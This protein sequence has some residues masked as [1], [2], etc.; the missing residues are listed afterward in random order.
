MRHLSCVVGRT[1]TGTP[2]AKPSADVRDPPKGKDGS[3][4]SAT[5]SSL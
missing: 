2:S 5:A 4:T 1:T 3:K